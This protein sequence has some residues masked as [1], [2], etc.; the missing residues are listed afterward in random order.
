[1]PPY[2][3]RGFPPCFL[4]DDGDTSQLGNF[5]DNGAG[6]AIT[7]K[8]PQLAELQAGEFKL[9]QIE[10]VLLVGQFLIFVIVKPFR[11]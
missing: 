10:V 7:L 11:G 8:P 6:G 2:L 3:H 4:K 9:L 1:M 5:P